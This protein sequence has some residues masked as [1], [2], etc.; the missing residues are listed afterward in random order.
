MTRK[1]KLTR[2]GIN[3]LITA[4]MSAILLWLRSGDTL[5]SSIAR[6]E[7]LGVTFSVSDYFVI[8]VSGICGYQYGVIMFLAA[9]FAQA[10]VNGGVIDGLFSLMI[11]FVI[12]VVAGFFAANRWY[13]KWWKSLLATLYLTLILGGS[14]YIVFVQLMSFSSDYSG[15]NLFT[16]CLGV[17]PEVAAA[18]FTQVLFFRF[19][20]D[21]IKKF[22]GNAYVYTEEYQNSQEFLASGHSVLKRQIMIMTMSEAVLLSFFAVLLS[23]A[24]TSQYAR[25]QRQR[26]FEQRTI[27]LS[28]EQI[29]SLDVLDDDADSGETADTSGTGDTANTTSSENTENTGVYYY[30]EQETPIF[31]PPMKPEEDGREF[32]LSDDQLNMISD[33]FSLTGRDIL[34]MD[35]QLGLIVLCISMPLAMFF[36]NIIVRKVVTPIK[37]MS[38]V[39]NDYF[40][41]EEE[42][43]PELLEKLKN[44]PLKGEDNEILQINT[45]MQ[46]M[47]SD[48]TNYINAVKHEKELE[49]ELHIAEARSEAKSV[50]LS[51][52]S[53]EIRTPINAVLGMNEMIL[54][55][56]NEPG[57]VAYAENIRNAGNTLLGI[58]NDILDFSKIEAGKMDIIPVDYDLA[59]VLNDLVTMIQTR[60]DAKGLEVFIKVDSNIPNMLHGDEI[61]IKQVVTNILTNAVKYT[62]KGSVTIKVSYEDR[63]IADDTAHIGLRFEIADTG[64]G[65]KQE[66]MDKLFSAFER[67]EEERN[68]TIE[69]TGLGMNITQRLLDMMG[70]RLEVSSVY[71][72]GST[73]AFT[74]DQI[75]VDEAPIGNYEESYRRTLAERKRYKEKFTAPEAE[76]LVVDDTR[77]NLTVFRSLLKKTLVKIDTAESGN[78]CI[79]LASEKKYDIIFLD[80]RMPEKD[81]I[82]TLQEMLTIKDFV[83]ADTPMICLTANAVSGAKEMYI[84]AGFDDYLTKP[85]DPD[86]LESMLLKYLPADKIESAGKD[87]PEES[88]D[89]TAQAENAPVMPEWLLAID[90]ID[91]AEGVRH[92][93]DSEIYLETLTVYAESASDGADEIAKLWGERDIPGVTV[94]VHALKSTSRVIGAMKLGDFAEKLEKAGNDGDTETLEA[95]MDDL[96]AQYR[97]LGEALSPLVSD[98]EDEDLPEMPA[99]QL[100][101]AYAAIRELAEVFDY[102]S[103]LFIMDSLEGYK[104]PE[105]EKERFAELKKAVAKPDWDMIKN[106]LG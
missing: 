18:I 90:A 14:L 93:G 103:V 42:K 47:I 45:A 31:R 10:L 60:A 92:C 15:S 49:S 68:R 1:Q 50:F 75:V 4:F 35:L 54:R 86:H 84:S 21:K 23:N 73:F 29:D 48:M 83:N 28:D 106:V 70:T 9:L 13:V 37:T 3:L 98:G 43:R 89:D 33:T 71:G 88:T 91:T 104:A 57:T 25:S 76:I 51:N 41:E 24:Q 77:M 20:P 96:I 79:G 82:E 46:R 26:M 58:V 2:T 17:F 69:G 11:Y 6:F 65:I 30:S 16:L 36:N 85:I 7:F 105:A 102:D 32:D 80:H 44:I 5:A 56:S 99:E 38:S 19:V 66:D 52:M 12:A 101:E 34:I 40:S 100:E 63:G 72:E 59:S 64:I 27:S 78:E 62:E 67:I 22:V 8:I 74:V 61:R 94:K 97:A 53:H 81:G 87:V 39:M 95:N 55:E